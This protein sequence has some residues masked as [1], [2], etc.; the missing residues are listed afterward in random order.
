MFSVLFIL[1]FDSY[2][3]K[4]VVKI[5]E[6]SGWLCDKNNQSRDWLWNISNHSN[7]LRC[8]RPIKKNGRGR[9]GGGGRNSVCVY[10]MFATCPLVKQM[11]INDQEKKNTRQKDR[12]HSYL[13]RAV[14]IYLS[15]NEIFASVFVRLFTQIPFLETCTVRRT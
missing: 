10:V 4:V 11:Q 7:R 8:V 5:R 13:Y 1:G 2:A 3:N 12:K 6:L 15:A 14:L 9:E